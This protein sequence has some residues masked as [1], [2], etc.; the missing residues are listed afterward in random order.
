MGRIIDNS[1]SM[2]PLAIFNTD[3]F[4]VFEFREKQKTFLPLLVIDEEN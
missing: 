1:N 3:N 2:N 4:A